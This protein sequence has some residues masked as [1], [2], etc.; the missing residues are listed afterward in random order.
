[1]YKSPIE[2]FMKQIRMKQDDAVLQAVQ[3]IGVE[4]HKDELIKALQYD[5][6]QYDKG[7][8]D[9]QKD[10]KE[11][12]NIDPESLRPQGAWIYHID[13]LFPAEG[14]Q[15]CSNCHQEEKISLCN[16]NY[17]PNCGAKMKKD[18]EQA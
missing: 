5:R 8:A 6:G 16:E 9:G 2:I 15:E 17:C 11:A 18:G 14:T 13:D 4:V 1:M 10:A 7:Y 3:D 12:Q